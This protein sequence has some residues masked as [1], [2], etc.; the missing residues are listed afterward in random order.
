MVTIKG[1]LGVVIVAGIMLLITGA[2]MLYLG[3]F[4]TTA[5]EQPLRSILNP[6]AASGTFTVTGN[7]S[8][9]E[10]VNMTAGGILVPMRFNI[11]TGCA[12]IPF[13]VYNVTVGLGGNGSTA[14]AANISGAINANATLSAVLSATNTSN[15]VVTVTYLTTGTTGNSVATA[16]TMANGSWASATLTGGVVGESSYATTKTNVNTTFTLLGILLLVTGAGLL[17]S[18]LGGLMGGFGGSGKR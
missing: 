12:E 9:G 8:C 3:F 5:V 18:A 13:G 6:T 17:I 15:G 7:G 10:Y 4:I 1:S 16:D 14:V 2:I 11:S